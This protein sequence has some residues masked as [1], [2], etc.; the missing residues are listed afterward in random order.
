MK[1]ASPENPS[2]KETRMPFLPSRSNTFKGRFPSSHL[3]STLIAVL[4]C[5][6]AFQA[7]SQTS[8]PTII[9]AAG[10]GTYNVPVG[11]TKVKVEAW[12]AGGGGGGA[13]SNTTE[14]R[15]GGG[16]G[17]GAYQLGASVT[18][19]SG[20]TVNYTV[21]AGGTA[22]TLSTN[23]G[24]GG[25]TVF[26]SAA[27]VTGNGGSGGVS[28]VGTGGSVTGSGGNKGTGTHNG[29]DGADAP[30]GSTATSAGG[31]G[32]GAGST[33]NGVSGSNANFGAGGTGG[34][35]Q[36]G[37]GAGGGAGNGNPGVA[38]GG[39]GG[40]GWDNQGNI[41]RTGGVGGDGQLI[42]TYTQAT[43]TAAYTKQSIKNGTGQ[44]ITLT[45]S[46]NLTGTPKITLTG[47]VSGAIVTNQ[48]M[49]GSNA[50]WTYNA[51]SVWA[52]EETIT[53]TVN[54]ATGSAA[55]VGN[56]VFPTP[57]NNTFTVDNTP[58]TSAAT[59]TKNSLRNTNAQTVTITSNEPLTV[60]PTITL[61]GSVSG[62]IVTA[63]AMAGGP[64]VWTYNAGTTWT[65][66]QTVTVTLPAG[67]DAAGNLVSTPT[68]NTFVVDNN[69]PTSAATYT[70]NAVKNGDAQ[71]VT[72]TSN[73]A[74]A[75][76]PTITLT[77]SVSGAIATAQAMAGGP[78]IWT[79]NAGSVWTGN[80]TVTVTLPAGA[81][82][83]GNPVGTPTT[84]T[85]TV[86]NNAPT[87]AATYTKNP[88]KNGDAQTVTITTNEPLVV[89]PTITL[90]GSVSGAIATAQAMAGGPSVW[91]YVA[92]TT[93]TG[94]Q[95]VTVTVGTGTDAAGNVIT[96]APTTNTFVVDNTG[97][98][99]AATYTKNSVKNGDSETVTVT[100]G[101]AVT[102]TP[103]ITLTGSVSGAIATAQ[104]MAG[105]P[106]IW[107]YAAGTTWAGD[108]TVTVTVGTATD[109]LGN[110]VITNPTTNTF[111]VDNTAPTSA[112]SY[113]KNPLR[114]TNPQTVTITIN[115]PISVAPTV[116]LTGSVS[117]AIATAQSMTG[118]PLVWTYNAG[119]TWTGN[120]T[121]TVTIAGS[122][123]AGNPIGTPTSNT[124][125]VDN[126]A[127]VTAAS[128]TKDPL[129][130]GDS[131]TVTITSGEAL[132]ATPT[133][134]LTGSVSGAI[135]T[136]AALSGGPLIWT[137]NAGTSWPGNQ[138]VTV[139]LTGADAA[140][141]PAG[142]P[143]GNTFTVDNIG[144][145]SSAAYSFN[146]IGNL[147]AQIITVTF[148]EALTGTP[149]INLNGSVS[150]AMVTG[151]S[152]SGGPV[153]WTYNAG[154]I[155]LGNE[156]VTVTVGTATDLA[157]NV[158]NANPTGN[159]FTVDNTPPFV[160]TIAIGPAP[161]LTGIGTTN[162]TTASALPYTVTFNEP[163][164][165]VDALDF[166]LSTGG[167]VVAS[168][169]TITGGPTVYNVTVN[170]S[171]GQGAIRLDFFANGTVKD[172][173]NNSGLT[174]FNSG[175]PGATYTKVLPEPATHVTGF[176][177]TPGPDNYSVTL[178]WSADAPTA[179]GYLI[180]A[181]GQLDDDS[182]GSYI[183][184]AD[185]NV[186]STD[187]T[188]TDGNGLA[189]QSVGVL[190]Y[191]FNSLL[192][193]KAYTFEI[194]PYAWNSNYSVDNIDY[195]VDG[196][197]P[198]QSATVT[199]GSLSTIFGLVSAPATISS[200]QTTFGA[201]VNLTFVLR[202]D[203]LNTA[204]D[205]SRTR[206]TDIVIKAGGSNTVT[207]WANVIE[208]AQLTDI[209]ENA[210]SPV[211]TTTIG[212]NTITFSGLAT[213]SNGIG[214]LDDNEIK[215]YRLKIRLKN[216][217]LGGAN[218]N[219]DNQ[220]FDFLVN[221]SSFT[222][223]T[224]TSQ[225][226]RF[227]GTQTTNTGPAKNIVTVSATAVTF[228]PAFGGVQPPSTALALTNLSII[229]IARA[230]D[231]SG[232]TD[233]DYGTPMNVT[234][235]GGLGVTPNPLSISPSGGIYTFPAGFQYI[236][237]GTGSA[238]NG[239]LTL[240][241]NVVGTV[242]GTS[243][244]VT[245]SF[246]N[247]T[248]LVAGAFGEPASFSSLL[249]PALGFD[250][251]NN[252][253]FDFN[254]VDD[255]GAGG[256]GAPTR[257]SQV[258]IT[259]GPGND[260]ADWTQ[261]INATLLYDGSTTI[262]GVITP[263]SVTF[264]GLANT[265]PGDFGYV[266]DNGTRNFRFYVQLKSALGG[267]L[268]TTVDGLNL[269]YEILKSG[270]TLGS[271]SS[272]IAL[273]ENENSGSTN[274]A[275]DVEATQLKFINPV[276]NPTLVS[277]DISIQQ[278][279]PT[280]EATDIYGNRD[281]NYNSTTISVT[282]Q[283]PTTRTI[284]NPPATNSMT[285]GFLSFPNNFQMTSIGDGNA[286][287]ITVS[288][289]TNNALGGAITSQAVSGAFQVRAGLASNVS[290][291]AAAP[292]T[293]SSITNASPGVGVFNF[294]VND[295]PVGTPAL[296]D[297]GSPTTLLNVRITQ[298]ATN[299]IAN[300]TQAIAGAIL[301]DGTPAHDMVATLITN[302]DI[303]FNGINTTSSLLATVADN[304][305]KTYTL[306]IWLKTSLGGTLPTSIDGLAF[307][308]ALLSDPVNQNITSFAGGTGMLTAP[309]QNIT[310][311]AA[312]VVT[313]V[314]TKL[315]YIFPTAPTNSASLNTAFPGIALEAVD[316][317]GARDLDFAGAAGTVRFISNRGPSTM[318]NAPV[319][320]TTA[321]VAGRLDFSPSF[322]YT[323]GSNGD[324]V[325]IDIGAGPGP[326]TVCGPGVLCVPAPNIPNITLLSSFE[327]ALISDPTFLYTL[328]F[329]TL[330]YVAYPPTG[331]I[332][333][334]NS[335]EIARM[336]LVDGSRQNFLYG[337]SLITTPFNDAGLFTNVDGLTQDDAD[338]ASTNL[339]GL[340]LRISNP[341]NLDRI[342][343]YSGGTEIADIAVPGSPTITA[344]TANFDFVFSGSPLLSA[345]DHLEA[346]LS[347]RV[348]FKATAPEVSD[349]S[350]INVAV[351]SATASGGSL[352]FADPP[353]TPP[354]VAVPALYKGGVKGGIG[355]GGANVGYTTPLGFNIVDVA[356]IKLDFT[357]PLPPSFAGVSTPLTG[358]GPVQARDKNGI[359]DLDINGSP[360][361]TS[362]GSSVGP[363]S[364]A[365]VNG[366]LDLTGLR[367]GQTGNG[368]LLVV[369][370]SL[371]SDKP[372][373]DAAV[374]S[375]H[376][377]VINVVST[378]ATGGVVQSTN[379]S[380][381]SSDVV[382]YGV[383][384]N[385]PYSVTGEPKLAG[386]TISFSNPYG[387]VF[388][389]IRIY[390]SLS[391]TFST[392]LPNI[393]GGSINATVNR[394]PT[395][396]Q[397]TFP[398]A[399][400]PDLSLPSNSTLTYFVQVDVDPSASAATPSIKPFLVDGG[401]GTG[402]DNNIITTQGSAISGTGPTSSD[403]GQ[404]YTF[405]STFPP[406]ITSSYPSRAQLNV[407]V[408]QS[409]LSI[410]F[411]VPVWSLDQAAVLV[412]Q[413]T[414]T[415]YPLAAANGAYNFAGTATSNAPTLANPL[416]FNL[417][418]PLIADHVY[419]LTIAP[420]S[421]QAKTGIMDGANNV[422]QGINF[423]GTLYFKVVSPAA[424]LLLG[425][426]TTPPAQ[427]NPQVIPNTLSSPDN[428]TPNSAVIS[429]T[430]DQRGTAYYMVVTSASAAPTL[431]DQILGIAAY[432]GTVIARG[433]FA[434]NQTVPIAQTGVI[435]PSV[436]FVAGQ[437]YH[438]WMYA[439]SYSE[440]NHAF[441]APSVTFTAIPTS[442]PYGSSPN[443][444]A[445]ASGPTFI[446]NYP[447][448]PP[449]ST[450]VNWNNP[451]IFV[452]N[453]SFQV[454]NTP[455]VISEGS[456]APG[457]F[458][459][460][461]G[462]GNRVNMNIVLPA[463][464]QFDVTLNGTTP[465]YGN[466]QLVGSDFDTS[467]GNGGIMTFLGNSILQISFISKSALS[468]DKIIISG[469]RVLSTSATSGNMFR[470][471]GQGIP[472]IG[473]GVSLGTLTSQ[474]APAIT[475]T[476]SYYTNLPIATRPANVVTN[477]P[478]NASP[479]LI[480]L[481]PTTIPGGSLFAAGDF[482]PS[483]FSGQ[484]VNVNFLNISAIAPDVP[485]NITINHTDNNGCT[486]KNDVQYSVYDHNVAINITDAL[487]V[488][489]T[490]P[491]IINAP[492]SGTTKFC[493]NFVLNGVAQTPT[494]NLAG[495]VR[496]VDFKNLQAFYLQTLTA[497]VPAGA[498]A[499]IISGPSWKTLLAGLPVQIGGPQTVA[500]V[501]GTFLN[502]NF[503]DARIADAFN[504]SAGYPSGQIP[505]PYTTFK[506]SITSTATG[507]ANDYYLGGSLGFVDL[508]GVFQ[509]RT[510]S[511]V[512]VPRVQRIEFFLPPIPIVD[513][514]R[515]SSIDASDSRNTS[516][517]GFPTNP[518]TLVYCEYGGV[519]NLF[520]YPAVTNPSAA[521]GT[522]RLFNMAG[523][524]ITPAGTTNGFRDN[525]NGTAD[526]D[527]LKFNFGYDNIKVV[528]QYHEINSPCGAQAYQIIRIT[529]NPVVDFSQTA[530]LGSNVSNTNAYCVNNNINFTAATTL[531]A[532]PPPNKPN[533]V[534][535]YGWDFGDVNAS[536]DPLNANA[537]KPIIINPTHNFSVAQNYQ[538]EL[539][540]VSNWGCA[541]RP[542]ALP[543][544]P[545]GVL[546]KTIPVGGIP[547]VQLKLD[548][549]ST[550]DQFRFNSNNTP[551]A[552]FGA[553]PSLA[554][555][556]GNLPA[557]DTK[558][559]NN[560]YDKISKYVWDFGD[561]TA[562]V[563]RDGTAPNGSLATDAAFNADVVSHTYTTA[564]HKQVNLTVTSTV[565]CVNSLAL[566]N[567]YRDL[568][569]LP[570]VDLTPVAPATSPSVYFEKFDADDGKWQVWGTGSTVAAI[571]AA[572]A[573][574]NT[575]WQHGAPPTGGVIQFNTTQVA[576]GVGIW[577]TNIANGSVYKDFEKSALFSPSFDL[578]SLG[579]PMISFNAG[580]D[581]ENS[582]GVV[583]QFSRDNLNIADPEKLWLTL[584]HLN[585]GEFWY[586][587]QGLA[588]KPGDQTAN[589]FGWSGRDIDP[590]SPAGSPEVLQFAPKHILDTIGPGA[591]K[592]VFRFAL[593]GAK[594]QVSRE[595]FSVDNFRVGDRTRTILLESFASTSNSSPAAQ[596]KTQN[597]DIAAFSSGSI[598]TEVV[599]INY[600][601]NFPNKDP[602]NE[603]NPADP[604]S[605][606]L[607]Y[608]IVTTP[609]SR[610]DG[611]GDTQDR[612]FNSW[613]P[614]LYKVRT[615]QLAQ[616]DIAI[617]SVTQPDGTIS[618]TPKITATVLTGIP[619]NTI[620][621]VAILE[622]DIA[623]SSLTAAQQAMVLTGE[624]NFNY[625]LK[626]MLPSAA[627][628][629]FGT[630]LPDNQ[631][632]AF[633]PFTW[634]PDPK[635]LYPVS[636]DLA[637]AVF[638]QQE[639]GQ[640]EVYQVE[641]LKNIQEPPVVTGLEPVLA[642]DVR[643]YPVPANKEMHV[644][645]PGVLAEHA[646]LEMIDQTGRTALQSA[647]PAGESRKTINVS[648]LAPG[649]YI[650]QINVG[651]GNFTRKK[652]MVV[653]EGN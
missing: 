280:V 157:G 615:L 358:A 148:G 223:N 612:L 279:V 272:I 500:G 177:A 440:D 616:A 433:S 400:R 259:Q 57:T 20:A 53:V 606:A 553:P 554:A 439:E 117:G 588:G 37:Q 282:D 173:A 502:Y 590:A 48:N 197:Q 68:T 322:Q 610:L 2:I 78:L 135:V 418:T 146:P 507:L 277:K 432:G 362:P 568:I 265:N 80:Q 597:T 408:N 550:T 487:I 189:Y 395:S 43:S 406:S 38:P 354:G 417:P 75:T 346:P 469:L 319:A 645:M 290:A 158:V 474:D 160:Q 472:A 580:V 539:S 40:G 42:I 251:N 402:T 245:V 327:S 262:G 651:N 638:L 378:I 424:P 28:G 503:D 195:K 480:Q 434:I 51:G 620:L 313:V 634:A 525:T 141:N 216:P 213:G 150:G 72:I 499:Q 249:T 252:R 575:S 369:Q 208:E 274:N 476:N 526:L 12:G 535:S 120:Q 441:N 594:S 484:G 151:V 44:T 219:V 113:T 637:V 35:G 479:A 328:P 504:V 485:F 185:G 153:V 498:P 56:V 531:A 625:V 182:N 98:S 412:D 275:I 115:E 194:I 305:S 268:P 386:F 229:P 336:L 76:P 466:L 646:P 345:G 350:P 518:G 298:S 431:N 188:F 586:T 426:I 614:N 421:L 532:A 172:N 636:G 468:V 180:R 456:G 324:D 301:S 613:V 392:G 310:S 629:P 286:A 481:T 353:S 92:G 477:I 318:L 14:N 294:V 416:V 116:T 192:S 368:T 300:W 454:M 577:K 397:V 643:V 138:T 261:V 394:L 321:F 60:A 522:F 154:A 108:E 270:I 231:A 241:D 331:N 453:N 27:P 217:M 549:V 162:G 66:N 201:A 510:N 260:I 222:Y 458:R 127:P 15:A 529:P 174:S 32:G 571:S 39:G 186:P 126:N 247:T 519:I 639:D 551:A 536:P 5:V 227:E 246:S 628:T 297:D 389:N 608:N 459:V 497:D 583:L 54:T 311:G 361:I 169:G 366:T 437:T 128:Y 569:V 415:S 21:G 460:N 23:G 9:T 387:S 114:N 562:T 47:S 343:L 624:T 70:K 489:P 253:V 482:G 534:A 191:T 168:V 555:P 471:G 61:T 100:F 316:A 540:V 517:T 258:V 320:G 561:A 209:T 187:L 364:L 340:T 595:G 493:A 538:V 122:D 11:I 31:G 365:F 652:V 175:G 407:D 635:K 296:Q 483:V 183:A 342:A 149:T 88:L 81:D 82:A 202:E 623:L 309:A 490:P 236:D 618:I 226:S 124:F 545:V 605:R 325:T 102:G 337:S 244:N 524:D 382:I 495:H 649:V 486:S 46:E 422:F 642:E 103:T 373:P 607:F 238:N 464:F 62:A 45:F 317:N 513:A 267:S 528:Y 30:G 584:G 129:K 178:T 521:T 388:Q 303:Q 611:E 308:F 333:A 198:S 59:Y 288:S 255:N 467:P 330:N 221:T 283:N 376:I 399:S 574:A 65:G 570:R 13:D 64:L 470:L 648:D 355:I 631:T 564:G 291:G 455:I 617:T 3:Y 587:D 436:P 401:F 18:V 334:G 640:H 508:T 348:T 356:A 520:G 626:K 491:N 165:G 619:A 26:S 193:G 363:P 105:G 370:G 650:L 140:G 87:S 29:G 573:P 74:L 332:T 306:K 357:A 228:N 546:Q 344:A 17:G 58:P 36:G 314:A 159:T 390:Q 527:P 206:F 281:L 592:I 203:F 144:P 329:T 19:T 359:V 603:D 385:T 338:G 585:D 233:L 171:S 93:W 371:R 435:T 374:P 239:T 326:G 593:G 96:A 451:D 377:D 537:N 335:L 232:N 89:S 110:P 492:P 448:S 494:Y 442:G 119:T 293:I 181:K 509:S 352:F 16:G 632:R 295:D 488:P 423:S 544:T 566:Q 411:S 428:I 22:G 86:D 240:T 112:A 475:F 134:T 315:S 505:D 83:A 84:N 147:N 323:T 598:G 212:V 207:N 139:T 461:S 69:A 111:T 579:R 543:A 155:W 558:I 578:H 224:A 599:K 142:T 420:G 533:T 576:N 176:T 581:L 109:A 383:T 438:V 375:P 582:D 263:T 367:Y 600:H 560:T 285:N 248:T 104:A 396:L 307:G 419:Y 97:P 339:T 349:H 234:T 463:G 99:S 427:S 49:A 50:T 444:T 601:L 133:V 145:T 257:I 190:S 381:G 166:A 596:E 398:P 360:T 391:P 351:I 653:H 91:T 530:V 243:S 7:F 405:A 514:S 152:M 269:S 430:F 1:N 218:L 511:T 449:A 118:G 163:V 71:T 95:T 167:N 237:A 211:L 447:A 450:T 210:G 235:A 256:D 137:Y 77:G 199:T 55:G 552:P 214:A 429:A 204:I 609:R 304:A 136:G 107:T 515:P 200:V 542:N 621:H 523:T 647:I 622:Q 284:A 478:D 627:G 604:S 101:E 131:Q 403:K 125:V 541:S 496:F 264:S 289:T 393:E 644:V 220:M 6:S 559:S 630:V 52:T 602:F 446:F 271:P 41:D 473:D 380:G 591:T 384:F 516:G 205:N 215:Q 372:G 341:S 452:C 63:Q 557:F 106:I 278:S 465:L 254:V 130:N 457:G 443:F 170:V 8:T 230:V 556:A 67:A 633:G 409:T 287:T 299:S 225:P 79:Y 506:K 414:G 425:T 196:S 24:D 501:P 547:A 10:A 548:G 34:G 462:P 512:V 302:T 563:T 410:N 33:A 4:L 565:G 242:F 273:G 445:G 404:V 347:V 250:I 379:L 413:N 572:S 161:P 266:A 132:V 73:E 123:V 292:A 641:L 179:N 589:D 312:D 94:D 567:S 90:T 276:G 25:N 164:T 121:V 156:V 184:V 85:F 143:S